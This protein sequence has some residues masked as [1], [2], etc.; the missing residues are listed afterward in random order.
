[1]HQPMMT[2]HHSMAIKDAAA[3]VVV[4]TVTQMV[5]AQAD[6]VIGH[7]AVAKATL[8]HATNVSSAKSPNQK[9]LAAT[10]TPSSTRTQSRN[11][12]FPKI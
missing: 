4:A 5:N 3:A 8:R 10:T 6:Q 7:V 9:V 1:M 11:F 2:S 12:T